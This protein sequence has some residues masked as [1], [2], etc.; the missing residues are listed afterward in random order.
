MLNKSLKNKLATKRNFQM[1]SLYFS[2]Y[3]TELNTE[4]WISWVVKDTT[5]FG[6]ALLPS[7]IC[8]L[9]RQ[10]FSALGHRPLVLAK[11]LFHHFLFEYS[12]S[13]TSHC[14]IKML[15]TINFWYQKLRCSFIFPKGLPSSTKTSS[16]PVRMENGVPVV[17]QNQSTQPLQLQPSMLTQ[18]RHAAHLFLSV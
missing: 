15:Q 5:W 13:K 12:V 8:C 6:H 16:Y 1:A 18:V 14:V 10:H 2:S 9:Q 11:A 4:L 7:S 17:Q 3:I